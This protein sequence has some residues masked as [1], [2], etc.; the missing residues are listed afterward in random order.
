MQTAK[1]PNLNGKVPTRSL[2]F[3][4]LRNYFTIA[5]RSL[6]RNK[7]YSLINILGLALGIASSI[8]ILLWVN[9]ENSYDHF[10]ANHQNIF[11]VRVNRSINGSI[12]T[13]EEMCIPAYQALRVAD[14]RITNSCFTNNTYGHDIGYQNKLFGPEVLEVSEEFLGMFDIPIVKGNIHSLDEPKSIMLNES[15]AKEIFGDQDPI[16]QTIL[17]NRETELR[18]TGIYKD[19]P[20]NSSFWF[21]AL[22]P[23]KYRGSKDEWLT[24]AMTKWD[25]FYPR[26][27][28]TV[29]PGSPL[30]EINNTIKDI[31]KPHAKDASNPE[32]FLQAMDRW[33]LFDHFVNGKEAG[34]KIEYVRL[35][36][37]VAIL[38]LLIACINYMNLSTAQS[39]KRAREVGVRKTIGS[40]RWELIR[41]FL[42]ESFWLTSISFAVAILIVKLALPFYND[43]IGS[44]LSLDLNSLEVWLGGAFL[45]II[46]SFIA[47]CYPAFYLSSFQ[48]AKVLKGKLH[49]GKN[50]SLPRTILVTM[51]YSFSI[52]LLMGLVVV[53]Q[54]I[55]H[56]KNRNLGYRQD[57]LVAIAFNPSIKK[58]YTV[59]KNELLRSGVVESVTRS[60]EGIDVDWLLIK[61]D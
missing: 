25:Q 59:L 44:R 46:T 45:V 19:I 22:V 7:T 48:P 41:Q 35:F 38:T 53:Y 30:D 14:S 61:R 26:I 2:G 18:V 36:T 27:Y 40:G 24:N 5:L 29:Q 43:L 57:G 9:Y 13:E 33:Y 42:L 3:A 60:N 21:M 56:V 51:Q 12:N 1:N 37:W 55:E 58:N 49:A 16:N 31:L 11:Q 54:Q 15:M 39:Q 28:V 6:R 32:I 23:I 20:K 50:A 17:Y 4:L 47:G 34:G 10:A 8:L 52:F